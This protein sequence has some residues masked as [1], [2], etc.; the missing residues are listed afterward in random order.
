LSIAVQA[1]DVDEQMPRNVLFMGPTEMKIGI[2]SDIH[3]D[4]NSLNTAISVLQ[5]AAVN[6]MLCAGD[7]VERGAND[8]S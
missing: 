2:I 4:M 8:Q 7:L 3:G 1:N 5:N 6:G